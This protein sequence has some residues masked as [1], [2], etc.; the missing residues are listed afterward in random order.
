MK[1]RIFPILLSSALLLSACGTTDTAPSSSGASSESTPSAGSTAQTASLTSFTTVDLDGNTVDEHI[2]DD[3]AVTMINIWG[4][5]CGPC[6]QEMPELGELAAEYADKGVQIVGIV[7]DIQSNTDG[8][9][10]ESDIQNARDLVEQ[11]GANYTHLL[12]SS[13]LVQAKLQYV[14][15]VPETIFVD[16]KGNVVGKSYIGSRGKDDWSSIIDEILQEVETAK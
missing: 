6:L 11:T 3:Y 14:T 15:A 1:T 9:F 10:S 2:F 16:N 13:D 4:T 8:G 7:S 12:P 5:F